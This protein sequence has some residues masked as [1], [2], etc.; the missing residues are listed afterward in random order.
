MSCGLRSPRVR[1]ESKRVL[2]MR[3]VGRRRGESDIQ[4]VDD[5]AV[6]Y[7]MVSPDE[8]VRA[9]EDMAVEDEDAVGI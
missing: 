8:T 7:V 4:L 2:D 6:F 5:G 3:F 9:T 1:S